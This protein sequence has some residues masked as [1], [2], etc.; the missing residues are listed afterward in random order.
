MNLKEIYNTQ[1][2]PVISYEVFPPKDDTDGEKLESLFNELNKLL[3]YN[4]SLIS[5]TYG[6]GG[7][8]RNESVE[9]IRRIKEELKV[10]PMPHFTC[11]S[12]STKNIR[13]YLKTIESFDVKNI[14]ALRGDIPKDGSVCH[15]FKHADE[16]VSYIKDNTNLSVAVAGYPEGHKECASFEHDLY[17]LKQKVDKGA[18]VIFT[19][20]FFNNDHYFSFVK[21]CEKL[22]INI[23]IIPGILPVS[24]YKQLFKMA[25]MCKVEI[26][27]KL[28]EAL[29]KHQAD[30][31]Y[32][33]KYGIEYASNQCS[34]LLQNK[35][36]GLHFYTLNKSY[37]VGQILNNIL[38]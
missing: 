31:D 16:L 10:T 9:I 29:E 18:D 11:V 1:K 20:M 23:P 26:P 28:K 21:K 19:Q 24:S 32:T 22:G 12:T 33:K 5:V 25:D 38:S 36:R 4:P 27:S 8:N 17:Y 6:A 35:V 2:E 34:E 7:S 3:D 15:D 13:D 37:A 14:L 30:L